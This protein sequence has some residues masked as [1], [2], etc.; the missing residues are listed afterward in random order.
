MPIKLRLVR[1]LHVT[2]PPIGLPPPP[3][4]A[5]LPLEGVVKDICPNIHLVLVPVVPNSL[6]A[7]SGKMIL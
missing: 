7:N 1:A 2:P 4:G 5:L 3:K 6:E